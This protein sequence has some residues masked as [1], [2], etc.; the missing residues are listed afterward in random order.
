MFNHHR[1]R[2]LPFLI[3]AACLVL[4]SSA[5]AAEPD[6]YTAASAPSHVQ[7]QRSSSYTITLTNSPSSENRA[8]R[9]K[10]GIPNGFSVDAPVT[11]TTT[12]V[13]G[14]CNPSIWEPDGSL[15]ADS[16]INL[17]R[18]GGNS[19]G[20]CQ[21][22]TLTVSFNAVSAEAEGPYTWETDLFF[23]TNE[24]ALI[25]SSDPTVVV[26]GT[27]PMVT[28]GQKPDK[29]SNSRSATFTFT[30]SEP[31]TQC[32]VDGAG[33]APCTS[34]A[35]YT[36]LLDGPHAFT[37]RGTDAAGNT[38]EA[39]YT[40]TSET[41]APTAAVSSGPAPLSNGRSATFAFSADEP[42]SFECQL[43]GGGFAVCSSPAS[44]QGLGDGAHTFSV[45]PTDAVGNLGATSS[46]GWMIDAT[47]PETTLG[48][49]PRS[50]TTTLS[51]TFTFT[52][53]E[54]GAFACKLDGAAFAPCTSP[55]SYSGLK[56]SSHTFEVRS[57]DRAGNVDSTPAVHR[58]T[59]A[60]VRR[61]AKATSAL[62]VPRAGARVSAPPLLAWRRVA[63]ASYY[64]VQLYRGR[65][66][67]LSA[68]PVRTRLQLRARWTYLGQ[69]RKLSPGVYRWY[70]WPGYGPARAHRYGALLGQSK[71]TVRA[72]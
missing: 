31:F 41:R 33:F 49:R 7:P 1:R 3:G 39:T 42:S 53:S 58:W 47:A 17:K 35:N 72:S 28:I 68:W 52:A 38:G 57:I 69:N 37:V 55:K 30:A 61:A 34:P 13:E 26:D 29:V 45:R 21:G 6:T 24:F 48:S 46:Y 8:Q 32:N 51:A 66:K 9:A 2:R 22:A 56:R 60:V 12:G 71:F 5:A 10:I 63:R 59:I 64:N 25:G 67:V 27:A 23:E 15:I 43:D 11:A 20:L 44:Y 4:V 36:N 54:Q 16:K 62:L 70:V 65:L 14:E 18:P 50:G 19:T 40:W